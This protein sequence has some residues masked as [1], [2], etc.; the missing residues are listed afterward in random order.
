MT[1]WKVWRWLHLEVC[2]QPGAGIQE[3]TE[4]SSRLLSLTDIYLLLQINV[5]TNAIKGNL[6]Y[7]IR[8]WGSGWEMD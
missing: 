2:S 7:V 1:V 6:D 5:R 3:V 4:G 8:D